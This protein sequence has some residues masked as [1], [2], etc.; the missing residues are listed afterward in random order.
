MPITALPRDQPGGL[1]RADVERRHPANRAW[2]HH[3]ASMVDSSIVPRDGA[4]MHANANNY[5]EFKI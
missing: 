4:V 1:P 5:C 2:P 3:R